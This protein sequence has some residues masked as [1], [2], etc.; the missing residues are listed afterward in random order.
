MSQE[1]EQTKINNP[2]LTQAQA[3]AVV[4]A[5]AVDPS[6]KEASQIFGM[7]QSDI[8]THLIEEY[9]KPQLRGDDLVREFDKQLNSSE[10]S[11]LQWQVL[12]DV[13]KQIIENKEALAQMFEKYDDIG[14]KEY[15]EQHFIQKI[16][17]FK[18]PSWDALSSFC[19]TLTMCK[20]H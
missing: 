17:Q 14:F 12:V 20:W 1:Q 11:S 15:Y 16:N 19:A 18:S 6:L 3:V 10:C 2:L 9:I 5:Q 7:L 13:V 4:Q 8:Q